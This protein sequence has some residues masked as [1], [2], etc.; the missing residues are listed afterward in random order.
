MPSQQKVKGLRERFADG[1]FVLAAEGY[2]FEMERRGYLQAGPFVPEV[3]LEHPELVRQLTREFAHAGS[4]I[5]LAFTV[6]FFTFCFLFWG[7]SA[8][9]GFCFFAP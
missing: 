7:G 5:T 8:D 1:E 2:V 4:D 9:F 3:V 6:R